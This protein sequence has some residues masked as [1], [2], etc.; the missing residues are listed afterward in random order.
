[1][2]HDVKKYLFY[3]VD[4]ERELFFK[5]A[6]EAGIVHFVSQSMRKTEKTKSADVKNIMDAIKIL[7]GLPVVE[8][9]DLEEFDIA[10]GFSKKIITLKNRL[11]QLNEEERVIKLEMARVFVFGAFSK[12]NIEAIEKLGKKKN[13]ILLR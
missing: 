10:L 8:Q 6:Q 13:T 12:E 3:G 7:R 5:K 9:E 11:N 2:R 4:T 1:M